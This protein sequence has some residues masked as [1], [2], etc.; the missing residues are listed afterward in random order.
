M[1]VT[2]THS[3]NI[4]AQTTVKEIV[5]GPNSSKDEDD[6]YKPIEIKVN[7]GDKVIWIKKDFGIHTV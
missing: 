6:V 7:I 5:I 2:T 3:N 1:S 4:F